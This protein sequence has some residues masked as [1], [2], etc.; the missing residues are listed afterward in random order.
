MSDY[1][2]PS[3]ATSLLIAL[4]GFVTVFI[5]LIVLMGIIILI[6]KIFGEKKSSAEAP[7]TAAE[8]I[9]ASAA[10]RTDAYTGVKLN[11]VDDKTAALLMAI[12]ANKLGKELDNL[13]FIS[14]K[15]VK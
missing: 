15:E 14:I 3:F 6:S 4:I 8:P 12:V 2:N 7:S 9:S 10:E 5:V 1:L 11:G 13:R